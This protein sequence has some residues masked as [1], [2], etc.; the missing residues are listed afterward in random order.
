[1][2]RRLAAAGA[3]TILLDQDTKTPGIH[4]VRDDSLQGAK[5]AIRYLAKLGHRRIAYAHWDR[6]DMNSQLSAMLAKPAAPP[7]RLVRQIS[8]EPV[9]RPWTAVG[10]YQICSKFVTE[11]RFRTP[12]D[13]G[14]RKR[15]A[16]PSGIATL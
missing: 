5:D 8:P 15:A 16:T 6:R 12:T 10:L 1:M 11:S 3:T 14:R 13:A 7:Y 2:L 4:A 9:S